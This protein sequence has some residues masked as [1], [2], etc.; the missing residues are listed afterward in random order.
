MPSNTQ[1]SVDVVKVSCEYNPA[2]GTGA[3][4]GQV[5]SVDVYQSINSIPYI[6]ISLQPGNEEMQVMEVPDALEVSQMEA[7]QRFA[8][9]TRDT[10]SSLDIKLL[11][12]YKGSGPV[13]DG[14]TK[15]YGTP[16]A[17]SK[18]AGFGFVDQK[19]K[20]YGVEVY[21]NAFRPYIYSPLPSKANINSSE[22][23]IPEAPDGS[24]IM[25][26]MYDLVKARMDLF[27]NTTIKSP[28]NSAATRQ[29]AIEVHDV[30]RKLLDY[31]QKIC[32]A[33]SE[34]VYKSF[35][36]LN[37]LS[38]NESRAIKESINN[39]ILANVLSSSSNFFDTLTA[40][41]NSFQL[42]YVPDKTGKGVGKV[43]PLRYMLQNTNLQKR[44][45]DT[46]YLS[47]SAEDYDYGPIQQVLVQGVFQTDMA[48]AESDSK[49]LS[50]LVPQLQA[51]TI[52]V[53]P[54]TVPVVNGNFRPVGPP[55][56]LP[57]NLDIFDKHEDKSDITASGGWQISDYVAERKKVNEA[58]DK[59][60]RK[61]YLDIIKEYAHNIY[62]QASLASY[63]AV[64]RAPLDFSWEV[65]VRYEISSPSGVVLFRGFLT[66]LNHKVSGMKNSLSAWTTLVFSHV[67]YGSFTL[68]N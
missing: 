37:N 60:L 19:V 14:G 40:F 18:S 2:T 52:L 46:E 49:S 44:V 22:G 20:L 33:S 59:M 38:P 9:S 12:E 7:L 62:I 68:D 39:A 42:F 48:N 24:N 26:R 63:T 21:L 25:M 32:A 65:G 54:E 53:W 15:L 36:G 34:A 55:A 8:F 47:F 3:G 41:L 6:E 28:Y 29:M 11:A 4:G 13:L 5:D 30:N 43:L 35:E 61:E 66:Q 1:A 17:P 31:I 64:I 27:E 45:I 57:N 67:E 50:S 58:I 56:W 23:A 10:L 51:N 16:V